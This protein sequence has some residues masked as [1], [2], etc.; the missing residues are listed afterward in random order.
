MISDLVV[1][2]RRANFGCRSNSPLTKFSISAETSSFLIDKL[3]RFANS[4]LMSRSSLL[5]I[6][7]LRFFSLRSRLTTR[8]RSVC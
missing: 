7:R 1:D 6:K 2:L 5:V 3:E 8:K 4:S